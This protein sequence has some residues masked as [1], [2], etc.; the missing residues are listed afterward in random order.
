MLQ[1]LI[2]EGKIGNWKKFV[3]FILCAVPCG[4]EHPA[5]YIIHFLPY[6]GYNIRRFMVPTVHLIKTLTSTAARTPVS[7]S[8]YP[9]LCQW[10][11]SFLFSVQSASLSEP[12]DVLNCLAEQIPPPCFDFGRTTWPT[13]HLY[14]YPKHAHTGTTGIE[15]NLF[16]RCT[17]VH[18]Y[19]L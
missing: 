17:Y 6:C 4:W 10:N 18:I 14:S 15:H 8:V 13:Q 9:V 7:V 2:N 1:K 11:C 19:C 12:T 3:L 5:L 16:M